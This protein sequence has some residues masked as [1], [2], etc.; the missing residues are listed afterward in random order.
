MEQLN[1]DILDLIESLEITTKKE[2][3]Y[4]E[5]NDWTIITDAKFKEDEFDLQNTLVLNAVGHAENLFKLAK[6]DLKHPTVKSALDLLLSS[7]PRHTARISKYISESDYLN[8][9]RDKASMKHEMEFQSVINK[10]A[11]GIKSKVRKI[12][13]TEEA[14]SLDIQLFNNTPVPLLM[15]E[16]FLE[17]YPEIEEYLRVKREKFYGEGNVPTPEV[18]KP[19][20]RKKKP[21]VK[22]KK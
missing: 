11:T 6:A 8:S 10:S 14:H 7:V 18:K 16:A 22:K 3:K 9:D 4:I 12:N 19:T 20:P 13:Y 15:F 21:A 1:E 17:R 5:D 2:A